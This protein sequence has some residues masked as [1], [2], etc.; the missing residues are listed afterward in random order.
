MRDALQVMAAGVDAPLNHDFGSCPRVDG[1]DAHGRANRGEFKQDV[2][3]VIAVPGASHAALP[4]LRI[5][6]ATIPRSGIGVN[7]K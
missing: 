5:N 1:G 3:P 6:A 4:L 7:E 2:A